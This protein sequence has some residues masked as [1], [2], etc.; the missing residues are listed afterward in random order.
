MLKRKRLELAYKYTY[1][2]GANIILMESGDEILDSYGQKYDASSELCQ[3]YRRVLTE[4]ANYA[5]SD[6]RPVG[7]PLVNFAFVSGRYDGW[8]GF[9]GSSLWAQFGRSEWGHKDSEYSWD[10]TPWHRMMPKSSSN[11]PDA[12]ENSL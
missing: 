9:C 6:N 5:K 11:M 4:T 7:G 12:A 8:S 1:I 10:G 2:S 3:D